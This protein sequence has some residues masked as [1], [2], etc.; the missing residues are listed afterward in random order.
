MTVLSVER[1]ALPDR[2]HC[3]SKVRGEETVFEGRE[4]VEPE[5][6]G[7]NKTKWHVMTLAPAHRVRAR[8]TL[9]A[10]R[11][12]VNLGYMY[13]VCYA[14]KDPGPTLYDYDYMTKIV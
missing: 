2:T 6:R 14:W 12:I 13:S 9:R 8:Q 3:R 4:G 7:S 10:S 11:S 1:G 5:E